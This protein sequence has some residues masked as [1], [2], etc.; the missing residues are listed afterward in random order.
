MLACPLRVVSS[1]LREFSD[2]GSKRDVSAT[3]EAPA[4]SKRPARETAGRRARVLATAFLLGAAALGC[5]GT[6]AQR[7]TV[8]TSDVGPPL[9]PD[10]TAIDESGA[11]FRLSDHRGHVV[12]I[13]FF[14]T[15]CVPCVKEVPHIRDIYENHKDKGFRV[16][17]IS[18]EGVDGAAEV[19]SFSV[20]NN[21]PFPLIL[22][23]DLRITALFNPKRSAPL[24]VLIGRTGRIV[25]VRDGYNPGDEL[26]LA[27]EV[28]NALGVTPAAPTPVPA[29][30]DTAPPA[31]VPA[32]VAPN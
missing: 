5:G 8:T 9:A 4:A 22:D 16:V 25:S 21:L 31:A 10:F 17:V 12:L 28:E 11:P 23:D 26:T 32:P 19:K 29:A 6:N 18:L 7:G 20:R 30:A 13:T 2:P 27:R 24:S 3:N 15:W 1:K 14:A